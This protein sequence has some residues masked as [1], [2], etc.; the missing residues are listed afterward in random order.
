MST[1]MLQFWA[2]FRGSQN[3]T[4]ELRPGISVEWAARYA[5]KQAVA[6][7][8]HRW[9]FPRDDQKKMVCVGARDGYRTVLTKHVSE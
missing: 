9:P 3:V 6:A 8:D 1:I 5:V 2:P 7:F 4:V